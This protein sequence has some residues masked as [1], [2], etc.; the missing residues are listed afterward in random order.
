MTLDPL[1][2]PRS[3]ALVGASQDPT[4]V[5]GLPLALL[6]HH[7]FRGP[8]YPVN[9]KHRTVQG[10]RS[11]PDVGAVPGPV[12]LAII[13]L[14][15]PAA[16]AA[17]AACADRGVRAA[18][19]FS[20]GFAEVGPAGV[21]L[22]EEAG[23]IARRGR[24]RLLGP[25][26]QGFINLRDRVA[27]TFTA[28]AQLP[29]RAGTVGLVTQS[30]ALGGSLLSMAH[31]MGLGLSF[32]I[33]TGNE[34]DITALD[35]LEALL[36]DQ[37]TRVL[38]S[39]IEGVHD[40]RRLVALTERARQAGK[41]LVVL[42]A[43]RSPVGQQATRSH[44]G[45]LAGSDAIYNAL[46]RQKG[47]IRV[48]DLD[49]LLEVAALLTAGHLLRRGV[50]ILSSSGGAGVLMADA[51]QERGVPVPPLSPQTTAR[52]GEILPP[53]AS[54]QNPV[55]MTGQILNDPSLLRRC[56]AALL[57]EERVDAVGVALTMV[58][59]QLAKEIAEAIAEEA[60]RSERVVA[61]AWMAGGLAEQAYAI[62][63]RE[64]IPLYRTPTACARAMGQLFE[65][66]RRLAGL[67]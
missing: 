53:Y 61:V 66:S 40:G 43:G 3:I 33:S 7:G 6:R 26:C 11:F 14:A 50:A 39:Y 64:G 4:K 8:I 9:P 45:A 34:A 54:A 36:E 10:L 5:S 18:V 37:G 20:A 28:A 1:L 2:T 47:V 19:L 29:L 52:L 60:R 17:L 57:E 22:Q 13:A 16:L 41:P 15:A 63:R 25:N 27:A 24:I 35:C 65:F 12:D 59:G 23:E 55:D 32:W 58:T 31:D 51:C 49:E 42:K 48:G 56:L 67:P 21:K 44:T 30:G 46:F 62:L 38:A